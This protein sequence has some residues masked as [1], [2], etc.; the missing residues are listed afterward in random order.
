L[1]VDYNCCKF[2]CWFWYIF[3]TFVPKRFNWSWCTLWWTRWINLIIRQCWVTGL[4]MGLSCILLCVVFCEQHFAHI[5][6]M[7][8]F[9]SMLYVLFIVLMQ[10]VWYTVIIVTVDYCMI[11]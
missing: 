7:F 2:I 4:L 11:I 1:S 3:L 6:D 8:D 10:L 5:H 9:D